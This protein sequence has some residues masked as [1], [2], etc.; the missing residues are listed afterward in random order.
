MP[1]AGTAYW[2]EGVRRRQ[3]R[4]GNIFKKAWQKFKKLVVPVVKSQSTVMKSK[5]QDY[6]AKEGKNLVGA[7][8]SGGVGAVR[9]KIM[10]DLP[11]TIGSIMSVIKSIRGKGPDQLTPLA[12]SEIVSLSRPYIE[13]STTYLPVEA[14]PWNGVI[15]QDWQTDPCQAYIDCVLAYIMKTASPEMK[16]RILQGAF[17]LESQ[18]TIRGGIVPLFGIIPALLAA[19]GAKAG[20]VAS[21]AAPVIAAAAPILGAAAK[22]AVASAAGIALAEAS[23]QMSDTR[24]GFRPNQALQMADSLIHGQG[25][26]TF[27]GITMAPVKGMNTKNTK[28]LSDIAGSHIYSQPTVNTV[29]VIVKE[30]QSGPKG[31]R[32]K[33]RTVHID[34]TLHSVIFNT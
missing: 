4:G 2:R 21:A 34:Q 20:I 26:I 15:K 17:E 32:P 9:D 28:Y 14:R 19:I 31:G 3:T 29:K 30:G 7:L 8:T 12:V 27:P 6:L 10:S 23:R 24:G 22:G 25:T 33:Q 13:N 1:R 11:P 5:M 18:K 16:K